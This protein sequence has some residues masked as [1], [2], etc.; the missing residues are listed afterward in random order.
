MLQQKAIKA[1]M[2]RDDVCRVSPFMKTVT[3]E[4]RENMPTRYRMLLLKILYTKFCSENGS[5]CSFSS[6]A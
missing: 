3:L 2:E 6:Y 1:F 5:T 4:N